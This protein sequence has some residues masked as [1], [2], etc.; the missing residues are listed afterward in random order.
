[1]IFSSECLRN[2]E[3]IGLSLLDTHID[4]VEVVGG[5]NLDGFLGVGAADLSLD[6]LTATLAIQ[7]N[8]DMLLVTHL[9]LG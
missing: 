3:L 9:A 2:V 8:L 5:I 4:G 7:D 1:M 6:M